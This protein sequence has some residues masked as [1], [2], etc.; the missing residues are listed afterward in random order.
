MLTSLMACTEF[1]PPY[2]KRS[3]FSFRPFQNEVQVALCLSWDF[4][5]LRVR[6]QGCY[7]HPSRQSCSAVVDMKVRRDV[8]GVHTHTHVLI[9][10]GPSFF[11]HTAS[12]RT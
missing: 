6:Q 3:P 1:S 2:L 11:R 12:S 5:S 9:C 10:Y 7:G 8:V 4:A